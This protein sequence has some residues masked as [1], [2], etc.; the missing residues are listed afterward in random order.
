MK[1]LMVENKPQSMTAVCMCRQR[2][3]VRTVTVTIR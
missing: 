3:Y 1:Q 2:S